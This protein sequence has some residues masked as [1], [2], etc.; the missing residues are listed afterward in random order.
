[1][2]HPLI[3]NS[4]ISSPFSLSSFQ[5][6][7]YLMNSFYILAHDREKLQ[8]T[9]DTV[10]HALADLNA[11]HRSKRFDRSNFFLFLNVSLRQMINSTLT[12]MDLVNC[13]VVFSCTSS[14]AMTKRTKSSTRS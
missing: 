7:A 10:D 6:L 4:I 2:I 1:M 11:D 12:V 13:S 14:S 3:W 9:L 5:E 8:T